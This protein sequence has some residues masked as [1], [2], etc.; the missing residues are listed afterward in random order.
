MQSNRRSV[1]KGM[2]LGAAASLLTIVGSSRVTANVLFK[3]LKIAK[4]KIVSRLDANYEGLR[5]SL[6]WYVNKDPRYPEAIIQAESVADVQET[7]NYARNQGFKVA[8]RSSGHTITQTCLRNDGLLLNVSKLCRLE[9]NVEDRTAWVGPGTKSSDLIKASTEQGLAFPACHT[10]FVALGGYLLGGGLGWNGHHWGRACESIIRAEVITADGERLIVD[11][12]NHPDLLWAVRGMGPGFF[13]VVVA[14]QL[15]LYPVLKMVCHQR[16]FY[17]EEAVADVG[18]VML[19]LNEKLDSRIEN[20]ISLKKNSDLLNMRGM[21]KL[22]KNGISCHIDLFTFV[23]S[24]V[25]AD[26]VLVPFTESELNVKAFKKS[27]KRYMRFQ[28]LYRLSQQDALSVIRTT[29]ENM[30]TDRPDQSLLA[31]AEALKN[32]STDT[33]TII[34]HFWGIN[35]A[36]RTSKGSAPYF[37][38]HYVFVAKHGLTSEDVKENYRWLDR[39]KHIIESYAKGHYINE[40]EYRR[41]PERIKACY[42]EENWRL[43]SALRKQYDPTGVFHGYM[44][45]EI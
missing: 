20:F 9:I 23:D 27:E 30:W 38:D 14:F 10:G 1:L 43:I 11:Q 12:D 13:G 37:A 25:E 7:I 44:G 4:R 19:E 15:R 45:Y 5:A 28:D 36:H 39:N 40:T 8:I 18:R 3:N 17:A 16:Y 2:M 26:K 22:D 31:Y 42:S 41:Y 33:E 6:V 24:E 21:E 35:R 29:V 32:T 34:A